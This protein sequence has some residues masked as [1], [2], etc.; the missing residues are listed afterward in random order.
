MAYLSE[1]DE[2]LAIYREEILRLEAEYVKNRRNQTQLM[3]FSVRNPDLAT[4]HGFFWVLWLGAC[5]SPPE[6]LAFQGN[7]SQNVERVIR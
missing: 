5:K 2:S 3:R 1:L 6:C 7:T 4:I